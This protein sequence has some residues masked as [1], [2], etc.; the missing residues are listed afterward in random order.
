MPSPNPSQFVQPPRFD[1]WAIAVCEDVCKTIPDFTD[2][3][4][5]IN[6]FLG[7]WYAW[8]TSASFPNMLYDSATDTFFYYEDGAWHEFLNFPNVW[9]LNDLLT[10]K[11]GGNLLEAVQPYTIKNNVF[12][13]PNQAEYLRL[14]DGTPEGK[15]IY[16]FLN[17]VRYNLS[18]QMFEYHNGTAW[19][20]LREVPS[21]GGLFLSTE[22][23]IKVYRGSSFVSDT[24]PYRNG[25]LKNIGG[26]VWEYQNKTWQKFYS[27]GQVRASDDNL[28][29]E[30]YRSGQ[31]IHLKTL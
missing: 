22:G 12:Y 28:S 3:V 5:A 1:T 2:L 24:L 21:Q 8:I 4:A 17:C 27:E 25:D 14:A 20:G 13:D 15:P 30:V 6:G 16:P 19:L 29:L 18:E 9:M 11:P 31:W 26:M 23:E 7:D 10:F